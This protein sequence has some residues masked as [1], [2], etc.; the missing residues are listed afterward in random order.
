MESAQCK[1]AH[2]YNTRRKPSRFQVGELVWVKSHPLS[3]AVT[4]F[5]AKLGPKCKGPAKIVKG[6]G[7]VKYRI[8]YVDSPKMGNTVNIVN[9]KKYY[10][11]GVLTAE[12]VGY[13]HYIAKSICLSAFTRI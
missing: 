13:V 8:H 3:K 9:L 4:G 5:S 10:G 12:G 6:F 7:E 2:C 1:Q 11:L